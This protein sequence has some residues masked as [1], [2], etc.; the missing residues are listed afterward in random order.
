MLINY[1][2]FITVVVQNIS[3]LFL[4]LCYKIFA[5]KILFVIR[6]DLQKFFFF[7]FLMTYISQPILSYCRVN[8]CVYQKMVSD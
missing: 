5:H 4:Q 6:C 2:L 3:F 7:Y 8:A 1:C